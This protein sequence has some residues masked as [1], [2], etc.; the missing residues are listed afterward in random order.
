MKIFIANLQM[1]AS[2]VSIEIQ[3]QDLASAG[4]VQDSGRCARNEKTIPLRSNACPKHC[5]WRGTGDN[6]IH[7]DLT[8]KLD[9]KCW[10]TD[11]NRTG[12]TLG[13]S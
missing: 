11:E 6:G 8:V 4:P 3:L 13:S 12:A 7:R 5:A 9:V 10:K 2:K 1:I